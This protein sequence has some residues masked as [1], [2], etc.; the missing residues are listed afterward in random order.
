MSIRPVDFNGMIQNTQ[1]VTNQK[2]AEDQKPIVNQ[3]NL[4]VHLQQEAQ[5]KTHQEDSA[6]VNQADRKSEEGPHDYR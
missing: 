3:E 6:P 5:E 4:S 1:G 2:V